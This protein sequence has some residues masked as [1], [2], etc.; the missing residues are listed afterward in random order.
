MEHRS[1]SNEETQEL[2]VSRNK[3]YK[4]NLPM[5]LLK[6]RNEALKVG[7]KRCFEEALL[8]NGQIAIGFELRSYDRIAA[9]LLRLS[10]YRA[11]RFLADEGVTLLRADMPGAKE[12]A[13]YTALIASPEEVLRKLKE[14]RGSE[15]AIYIVPDEI[16]GLPHIWIDVAELVGF[17]HAEAALSSLTLSA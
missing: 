9:N 3:M 14:N 6:K 2:G 4:S 12:D 17:G 15:E 8:E 16:M 1:N 5:E 13:I 11:M 7:D 10:S